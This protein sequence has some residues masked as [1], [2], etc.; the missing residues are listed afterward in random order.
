MLSS[1]LLG[2]RPFNIYPICIFVH[3]GAKKS[4]GRLDK[5]RMI[6]IQRYCRDGSCCHIKIGVIVEFRLVK[7]DCTG[8][9]EILK[10]NTTRKLRLRKVALISKLA[11]WNSAI[12]NLAEWK[13]DKSLNLHFLKSV[14]A[15]KLDSRAHRYFSK[16]QREKLTLR[17]NWALSNV[18]DSLKNSRQPNRKRE[19]K[20]S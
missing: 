18:S 16:T 12:S 4:G 15:S 14:S 20:L 19:I 7:K 3:L 13:I 1:Q 10:R 17:E 5:F 8:G 9:M 11:D 2:A 6:K